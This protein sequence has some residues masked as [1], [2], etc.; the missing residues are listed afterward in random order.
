VVENLAE[1]LLHGILSLFDA[2]DVDLAED[3]WP[4]LAASED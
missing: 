2:P 3:F 1:D 4:D